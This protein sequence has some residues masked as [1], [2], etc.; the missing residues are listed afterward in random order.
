MSQCWIDERFR[1][2][3]IDGRGLGWLA[4]LLV[5][6]EEREDGDRIFAGKGAEGW[7]QT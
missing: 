7:R 4:I 6:E 1:D 3:G 2:S 5:E